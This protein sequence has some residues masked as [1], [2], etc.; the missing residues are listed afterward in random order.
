VALRKLVSDLKFQTLGLAL[1]VDTEEA[2]W[3]FPTVIE[4]LRK[5]GAKRAW[6]LDPQNDCENIEQPA[7]YDINNIYNNGFNPSNQPHREHW[8]VLYELA[9]YTPS[10]KQNTLERAVS[11]YKEDEFR[12]QIEVLRSWPELKKTLQDIGEDGWIK[13]TSKDNLM[14]NVRWVDGTLEEVDPVE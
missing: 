1:T 11:W 12:P 8:N 4:I 14:V 13:A 5:Y 6:E 7:D 10:Y 3:A 2:Y 9:R